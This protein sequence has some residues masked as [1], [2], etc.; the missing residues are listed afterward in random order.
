MSAS[1]LSVTLPTELFQEV[2]QFAFDRKMKL[3]H[4][5]AEAIR[6]KTQRMK[7]DELLQK[8]NRAFE[9]DDIRAEQSHMADAIVESM[10]IE[11]LPW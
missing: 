4:L 11:E 10:D 2:K 8:V 6:E 1:R 5:V 7:D 9:D 3:S